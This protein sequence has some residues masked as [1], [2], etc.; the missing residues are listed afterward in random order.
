MF[1]ELKYGKENKLIFMFK[2]HNNIAEMIKEKL[3]VFI[4][5]PSRLDKV[6]RLNHLFYIDIKAY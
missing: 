1:A 4:I 6:T 2:Q 3:S 5:F